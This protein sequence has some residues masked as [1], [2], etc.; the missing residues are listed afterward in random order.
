MTKI[1]QLAIEGHGAIQVDESP[2]K[3]PP[4][5]FLGGPIKHWWQ[6][7]QWGTPKHNEY[8]TWRT[9]LEAALVKA[10]CAVYCPYKAIR[11]RWNEKLQRINDAAIISSDVFINMTPKDIPAIG[12]DGEVLFAKSA[13]VPIILAPPAGEW[14][15][16]NLIFIITEHYL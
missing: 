8:I 16:S 12:T 15:L 9:A 1:E 3:V 10:G 5:V 4:I 14:E 2:D 7:G 11:G 13:D 6:D